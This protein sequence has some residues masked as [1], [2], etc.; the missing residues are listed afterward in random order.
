MIRVWIISVLIMSIGNTKDYQPV[1]VPTLLR[2]VSDATVVDGRQPHTFLHALLTT[3]HICAALLVDTAHRRWYPFQH[4]RWMVQGLPSWAFQVDATDLRCLR[5]PMTKMMTN[6]SKG[7][8]RLSAM[9]VL[10]TNWILMPHVTELFLV[11]MLTHYAILNKRDT[12]WHLNRA[13]LPQ[14]RLCKFSVAALAQH[15]Q[16]TLPCVMTCRCFEQFYMLSAIRYHSVTNMSHLS[17]L[18]KQKVPLWA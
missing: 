11:P 3:W 14:K 13:S 5:N 4:P 18:H 9:N 12:N 16:W 10:W 6:R 1:L 17:C 8:E 7:V 15:V 2:M